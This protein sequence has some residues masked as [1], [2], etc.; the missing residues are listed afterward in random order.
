VTQLFLGKGNLFKGSL[1][2]LTEGAVLSSQPVKACF[3]LPLPLDFGGALFFNPKG[4]PFFFLSP[5]PRPSKH[6]GLFFPQCGLQPPFPPPPFFFRLERFS[7]GSLPSPF[8]FFYSLSEVQPFFQRP[9]ERSVSLILFTLL[10]QPSSSLSTG[11]PSLPTM[12]PLLERP[13][14]SWRVLPS[15]IPPQV[16]NFAVSRPPF[17]CC[18]QCAGGS[19]FQSNS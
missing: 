5:P 10:R 13:L 8:P 17:K 6:S 3:F 11:F 4:F 1:T 18:S 15:G 16:W 9:R 7:P 2:L 12:F 19:F 14:S